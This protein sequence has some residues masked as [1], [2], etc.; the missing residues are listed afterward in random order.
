MKTYGK[1]AVVREVFGISHSKKV[2][3]GVERWGLRDRSYE[4]SSF[5]VCLCMGSEM[6]QDLQKEREDSMKYF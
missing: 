2:C 4:R 3:G 1:K 6:P 5:A